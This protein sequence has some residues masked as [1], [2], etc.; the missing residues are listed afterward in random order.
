MNW[1]D[2][3]LLLII[4]FGAIRGLMKG[5][6]LEISSFVGVILGIFAARFFYE[7]LASHLKIWLDISLRYA[8][9]LAFAT[10][11]LGVVII[12]YFIAMIVD[13]LVKAIALGWFNR[14]IGCLLGGIKFIL[15]LSVIITTFGI[16]NTKIKLVSPQTTEKS[17]LYK[18][19]GNVLPFMLPYFKSEEAKSQEE[20]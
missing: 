12:S 6:I 20:L 13:K 19:I 2:F 4:L 3:I 7:G 15:I 1:L 9:P 18:P 8:K 14:L 11:F 17:F 10:I 16:F 5:F